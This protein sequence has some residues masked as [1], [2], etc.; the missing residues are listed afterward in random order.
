MKVVRGIGAAP[1]GASV[2]TIGTFDA[3]HR[4]HRALFARVVS[5]AERLGATPTVLTFD[6]HP[7]EVLR[8]REAPC[9]LGTLDQRLARFEA[10]GI[11]R[12]VVLDFTPELAGLSPDAFVDRVLV[13]G[14]RVRK[15]I[16]GSDFRFGHRRAG[17]VA[18]LRHLGEARGFEAEEMELVCDAGSRISSS[19]IRG[20][21]GA[22][23]VEEASE[24]LGRAY[25][26]AGSVVRGA[27]RGGRLLGFPTANLA[28]D[29]RA[30]L[31]GQGVYAGWWCWSGR[32]LPGAINVG[33]RPTFTP[34][35]E[36]VIEIHILDF[37]EEL[38][39]ERGEIEF[40]CRLR[41]ELRFD[42]PEAL[43]EQMR[44]DVD[45]ARS[46]LGV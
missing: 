16:V 2:C 39:G 28:P 29:P 40:T 34:D 38:Y 9:R 31:P 8:P 46:V 7:L 18:M 24:L 6:R 3:V 25:R 41:D 14:L 17:D 33:V 13:D 19:E 37:S 43:V 32:R 26:V 5:E 42:S 35:P 10:E 45:D 15:V 4:G 21:V 12:A 27:G 1:E 30:C 11:D 23:R 20:L 22:G 36:P 44:R